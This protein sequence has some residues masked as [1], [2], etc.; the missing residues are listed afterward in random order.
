MLALRTFR[1]MSRSKRRDMVCV[2]RVVPWSYMLGI[3][4]RGGGL[5]YVGRGDLYTIVS[6]VTSLTHHA[7]SPSGAQSW[8][9]W[10]RRVV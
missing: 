8:K 10:L 1:V 3:G 6:Y 2:A 5:T 9:P 4:G 7:C